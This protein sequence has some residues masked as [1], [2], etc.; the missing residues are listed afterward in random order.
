MNYGVGMALGRKFVMKNGF[1][2]TSLAGLGIRKSTS[3]QDLY[4]KSGITISQ[5]F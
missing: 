2:I 1:S 5:R 4:L 3:I